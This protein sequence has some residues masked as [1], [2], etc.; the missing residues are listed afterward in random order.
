MLLTH[1]RPFNPI[2]EIFYSI[3]LKTANH[4]AAGMPDGG[5]IAS[6][7]LQSSFIFR[8][9][10]DIFLGEDSGTLKTPRENEHQSIKRKFHISQQ[11]S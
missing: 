3:S 1:Y 10:S 7:T 2:E 5:I 4:G 9:E 8:S 11:L 6:E